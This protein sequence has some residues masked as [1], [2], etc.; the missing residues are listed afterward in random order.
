MANEERKKKEQGILDSIPGFRDLQRGWNDAFDVSGED[1]RRQ[2]TDFREAYLGKAEA[3]QAS[4]RLGT[5][6]G[7]DALRQAKTANQNIPTAERNVWNQAMAHLPVPAYSP[8]NW[9]HRQFTGMNI[10]REDLNPEFPQPLQPKDVV[11]L[12]PDQEALLRQRENQKIIKELDDYNRSIRALPAMQ[13][14]GHTLGTITDE[15]QSNGVR[16]LWWL[17]NAPQA[18]VDLTSEGLATY[19][20]PDLRGTVELND[21]RK[22]V[23]EGDLKYVGPSDKAI[24]DELEVRRHNAGSAI[25]DTIAELRDQRSLG[26]NTF[27]DE[28]IEALARKQI[29]TGDDLLRGMIEEDAYNNPDNYVQKRGG[30]QRIKK[31]GANRAVWMK[32]RFSPNAAGLMS[33]LPASIAI[34]G[35]LRLLDRPEGYAA[36]VPTEDDPRQ[37]ENMIAE[38]ASRYILGREGKLLPYD[39]F[40]KERPDVSP[41]DYQAYKAY[42]FDK[43]L[44]VNPFDDGKVNLLGGILQANTDGIHGAEL[45]FLGRSMGWNEA[46]LPTIAALG[47]T[48]VGAAIPNIRSY[49]QKK[50]APPGYGE[51]SNPYKEA[52]WKQPLKKLMGELPEPAP[53]NAE[54]ERVVSPAFKEGGNLS[55]LN[56]AAEKIEKFFEYTPKPGHVG[57]PSIR[58]GRV[59]GTILATSAAGLLGG[60]LIG[61]ERE[62]RRREEKFNER[63]PNQDYDTFKQKADDL[64]DRK[65]AMVKANPNASQERDENK[66]S[67]NKRS[68]QSALMDQNLG[69]N[70]MIQELVNEERKQ[71]AMQLQAEG[72]AK[73]AKA[74]Q[75]EEDILNG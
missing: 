71:R 16:S 70:A 8:G 25:N 66:T 61:Q 46:L 34:N 73:L 53:R 51:A 38:V 43:K 72:Q 62:N 67:F 26:A 10:G 6:P 39:E 75:I 52:T 9:V 11:D 69:N 47:G 41:G 32:R 60:T 3:T 49:R 68:Y 7:L 48:A 50:I 45:E 55:K 29:D 42:K 2:L 28:E 1:R 17:I 63:F 59:L 64:M 30:V 35:G 20:A 4:L 44:D 56:P 54:G 24:N 74:M 13:K 27:S 31:R 19:V 65:V 5:I 23:A 14:V 40:S 21:L 37:T 18:V 22:A 58:K 57:P 36:V 12:S 33:M 15:I